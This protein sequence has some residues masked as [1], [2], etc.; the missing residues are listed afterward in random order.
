[1]IEALLIILIV[2]ALAAVAMLVVL[3]LR[4]T[5]TGVAELRS[6]FDAV[7]RQQQR[8]EKAVRDEIAQNRKEHADIAERSRQELSASM[9]GFGDS[10]LKSA[11]VQQRQMDSFALRLNQLTESNAQ[12]IGQLRDTIEKQLK[13]LQA[14]N[15]KKLDEMRKTVDEKL[16]GT[17]EKR[18]G[19]SFR[20]V[21]ERLEQVHKGLGEMQTL[22]TGVGDLKKVLTN[23]KTRGTWGEIQL[24]SLLEQILAPEQYDTNV[25]I[26]TNSGER[27]EFAI[28]MP[29]PDDGDGESVWLPIDA[30]FPQEDYQRLV[31]A[32]ERADVDAVTQATKQLESSVRHAARDIRDKYVHPPRTTDFALLFLPTEGLYAEVIRRPGLVELLQREYRVNV[33]GPTTLA[34][35]LNALQIGFRTQATQKRS[36]EVWE[37]LR[38]VRHEFGKFEDVIA[39]VQKKL[40]EASTA[41]ETDVARRTRVMTRTLKKVEQLHEAKPDKPQ[42][43]LPLTE[44]MAGDDPEAEADPVQSGEVP[45]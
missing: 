28:R 15:A 23:V 19:E 32:Q 22:A 44:A 20:Q 40:R 25:Q 11:E 38:N 42:D 3:L 26:R 24:G 6:G 16:Q 43:L 45:A 33:A 36:S 29:G 27:V 14:D 13:E 39:K 10:M 7:D 4:R 35:L 12:K 9:K 37:V 2:L 31:E 21:S 5:D 41:I 18:L 17:L 1:M 8:V 34:S 30:K